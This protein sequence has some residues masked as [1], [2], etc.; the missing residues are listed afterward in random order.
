M[1]LI[2]FVKRRVAGSQVLVISLRGYAEDSHDL[3][4]MGEYVTHLSWDHWPLIVAMAN[5][6]GI[7]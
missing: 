6:T 2:R 1:T 3:L 4:C 5:R 7:A